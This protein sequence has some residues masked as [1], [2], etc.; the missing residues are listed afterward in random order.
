MTEKKSDMQFKFELGI[1]KQQ[2][3]LLRQVSLLPL[4]HMK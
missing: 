3:G 2:E 1:S 4:T